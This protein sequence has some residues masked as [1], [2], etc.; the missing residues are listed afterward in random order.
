M[1]AEINSIRTAIE[2]YRNDNNGSFPKGEGNNYYDDRN[3]TDDLY[4]ALQPIV[5]EGYIGSLPHPQ[6]FPN[7]PDVAYGYW[8]NMDDDIWTCGGSE[9][10]GYVLILYQDP[11]MLTQYPPLEHPSHGKFETHRCVV[12]E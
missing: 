2:T 10:N 3:G 1:V 8:P 11:P 5:N 7:N 6:K 12:Y 9:P 4:N